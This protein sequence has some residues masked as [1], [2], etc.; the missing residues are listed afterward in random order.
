MPRVHLHQ[1][2]GGLLISRIGREQLLEGGF[3]SV[4]FATALAPPGELK[5]KLGPEPPQL[6]PP[7][8]RPVMVQIVWQEVAH[9]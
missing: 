6:L 4:L 8:G 3:R 5:L 9:P 2:T 7:R 1:L